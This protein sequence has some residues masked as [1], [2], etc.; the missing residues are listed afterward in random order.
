[1]ILWGVYGDLLIEE[2]SLRKV[3]RSIFLGIAGAIFV[4]W[5]NN[6]LPLLIVA[7]NVITFERAV[8]EIYKALIRDERQVKYFIPSDLNID[9][10]RKLEKLIGFLLIIFIMVLYRFLNS[11]FN[12]IWVISFAALSPAITGALKDAKYEGF[13][14]LKFF[15]TPLVSAIL[16]LFLINFYPQLES[17]HLLFSVWGGER[18]I[19]EFYKKILR[20]NVPGKFKRDIHHHIKYG[21][22]DSRKL[23]LVPYFLLL[24]FLISLAFF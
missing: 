3:L 13:Y 15:R 9:L 1:M 24:S 19:S 5:I 11:S 6:G 22:K 12:P 7:L 17:R 20:G 8:T 21:W 18:I 23:L 4:Y 2:F 16:G 14:P 10:P